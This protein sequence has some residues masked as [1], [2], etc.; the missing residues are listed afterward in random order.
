[1]CFQYAELET[2]L[3]DIERARAVFELA[4]GQTLLDMPEVFFNFVYSETIAFKMFIKY[5]SFVTTIAENAQIKWM[6]YAFVLLA[7]THH[8]V[9]FI[10]VL[11]KAYIDF[12]ISQEEYQK[13]RDLYERLLERT[14]HV[15]VRL[16]P[17]TAKTA[18]DLLQVVSFTGLLQTCQLLQVATGL[19]KSVWL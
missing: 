6:T 8:A 1:M 5:Y 2:I 3:G 18:T 15:K 13:T 7:Q 14:Q 12:E 10:K 17:Y 16:L 11:W 19:L 9:L 4:V